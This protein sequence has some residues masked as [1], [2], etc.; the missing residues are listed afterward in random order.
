MAKPLA[1]T[2]HLCRARSRRCGAALDLATCTVHNRRALRGRQTWHCLWCYERFSRCVLS[3]PCHGCTRVADLTKMQRPCMN[4]P[5]AVSTQGCV[6]R[7][8]G[9]AGL[10]ATCG[11][12]GTGVGG[13]IGT[14]LSNQT[15]ELTSKLRCV[16]VGCQ[17]ARRHSLR[18][19]FVLC[20]VLISTTRYCTP[21][22]VPLYRC[23]RCTI[24]Q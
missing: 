19:V 12:L 5:Q 23:T 4:R 8:L 17:S 13:L 3:A 24:P 16:E 1:V 9:P 14:T 2:Q 18:S 11:T 6:L 7:H 22:T 21:G 20:V 15:L 10:A